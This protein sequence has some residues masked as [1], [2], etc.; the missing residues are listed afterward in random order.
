MSLLTWTRSQDL[1]SDS[2]GYYRPAV[3]L[4][5]PLCEAKGERS[6]LWAS[7]GYM[8]TSCSSDNLFHS[9]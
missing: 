8:V 5:L 4:L 3:L 6:G 9:S 2:A 1:F 7:L